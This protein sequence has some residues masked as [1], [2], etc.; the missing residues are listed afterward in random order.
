MIFSYPKTVNNRMGGRLITSR[1]VVLVVMLVVLVVLGVVLVVVE[2]VAS[3][4]CY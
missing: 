4:D 1:V 2:V 3:H